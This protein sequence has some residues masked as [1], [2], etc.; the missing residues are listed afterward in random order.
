M[1]SFDSEM[2]SLFMQE[3]FRLRSLSADQSF[4]YT[5]LGAAFAGAAVGATW[6]ISKALAPAGAGELDLLLNKDD[7]CRAGN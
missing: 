6:A 2:A 7:G 3:T 5:F 1:P 4:G